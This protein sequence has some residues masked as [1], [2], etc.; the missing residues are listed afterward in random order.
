MGIFDVFTG[1]PMKQAAEDQRAY[2][3]RLTGQV[4]DIYSGAQTSGVGALQTGQ[5][6]ALGALS[7]AFMAAQGYVQG[8]TP[9]AINAL[10]GGQNQGVGALDQGQLGGLGALGLGVSQ[11]AG[12]YSPLATAAGGFNQAYQPGL[13]MYNRA[14]GLY[15]PAAGQAAVQAFQNNPAY[16]FELGQ[17]IDAVTRA[18]N[19]T[20]MGASG[21]T[22]RAA[23]EFG[24][25]L[26]NTRWDQYLQ[27]LYRP[28]GTFAPL[29]GQALAQAGQGAANAFLTGGTGAANIY[30]GTGGRLSDLYS[31]TGGRAADVYGTE[32]RTLADLAS[33]LGLAESGVYTGTGSNLANLYG[34]LAQGQTQFLGNIAQP[35]AKTY[36]DAAQ[37]EIGGSKNLWNLIGNAATAAATGGAS[38]AAPG[39]G[40]FGGTGTGGLFGGQSSPFFGSTQQNAATWIPAPQAT[41]WG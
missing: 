12:A 29:T 1:D 2:F 15:G 9:Q 4:K 40:L 35:Y 36:S 20:G 37:A 24:Q 5:T 7:P 6:G 16:Q 26:A 3:D 11:A 38:L 41:A 28:S 19:A 14:L 23:Q 18:A 30:T 32:G 27:N 39:G 17:G 34:N 22:L 25:N 21:N 10:Y 8:A 13:D 31:T 33:R